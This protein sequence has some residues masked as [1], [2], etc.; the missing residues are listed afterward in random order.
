MAN[1]IYNVITTP[2]NK[3]ETAII[4]YLETIHNENHPF[5][6]I[7]GAINTFRVT[8]ICGRDRLKSIAATRIR[9]VNDW[10]G[11]IIVYATRE[12]CHSNFYDG[13]MIDS[14]EEIILAE[15][16]HENYKKQGEQLS[17]F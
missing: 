5:D 9:V 11:I 3:I 4:A 6:L 15:I 13:I 17:I 12:N 1:W 14:T 7:E 16:L 8:L 2:R 10:S